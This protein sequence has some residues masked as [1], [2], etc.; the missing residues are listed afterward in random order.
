MPVALL[1][2]DQAFAATS[3]TS[4]HNLVI[5]YSEVGRLEKAL[6]LTERVVEARKRT[7]GDEHPDTLTSMANLAFTYEAQSQDT[8][9]VNLI[10]ECIRLRS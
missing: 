7:V 4:P 1:F 10:Q 8:K 6:Q 3:L 5:R 9:A 2:A